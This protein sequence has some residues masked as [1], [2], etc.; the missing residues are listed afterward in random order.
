M[1]NQT[2][3]DSRVKVYLRSLFMKSE[4]RGAKLKS[5]R[6]I[7]GR[8]RC[9]KCEEL[10]KMNELQV[11]HKVAVQNATNWDEYIAMMFCEQCGLMCV[12]KKCHKEIHDEERAIGKAKKVF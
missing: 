2:P 5:A 11:H 12:C 9:E 10:F 6:V 8:Y 1:K 3:I 4:Y 7:R